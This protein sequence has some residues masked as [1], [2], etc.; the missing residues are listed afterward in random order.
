MLTHGCGNTYDHVS[1]CAGPKLVYTPT[2]TTAPRYFLYR[3]LRMYMIFSWSLSILKYSIV[4]SATYTTFT[5]TFIGQIKYL[6]LI[7]ILFLFKH[8]ISC[9]SINY[10]SNKIFLTGE[11][12]PKDQKSFLS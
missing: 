10:F 9:L 1:I 5:K 7:T 12:H 6:C 8:N 2:L 3:V 11:L 4:R